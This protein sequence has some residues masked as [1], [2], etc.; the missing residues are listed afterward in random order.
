MPTIRTAG[1]ICLLFLPAIAAL[2]TA[3]LIAS[4]AEQPNPRVELTTSAG[5][6]VVEL[7]SSLAPATVENFLRY[8]EDDFYDGTIFHRVIEGFMIQGGGFTA[9]LARKATAAPIVNEANNGL[10]NERYTIAMAR[11]NAPHSATAQFF[12]N[13]ADNINL[14]HTSA[15]PR[16]WGYAV[17]GRVVGG[18]EIIDRITTTSTTARGPLS[19]D[20]PVE[21][22]VVETAEQL[23]LHAD[24]EVDAAEA[25]KD[26]DDLP[27]VVPGEAVD[28]GDGT[29]TSRSR[30]LPSR[31]G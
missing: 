12:I 9:E 18:H 6:I 4:E 11:T 20:V 5:N 30:K 28:D 19:R 7:D 24:V 15:S 10:S 21:A 27:A 17:F 25:I 8:V 31:N 23:D 22:I 16:G 29:D 26:D 3:P 1:A 2:P 13:T 14:D